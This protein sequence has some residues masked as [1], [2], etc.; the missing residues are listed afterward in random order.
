MTDQRIG[1]IC[2]VDCDCYILWR[3]G[4]SFQL[5]WL[6]Q[7]MSSI[8]K[9]ILL[10]KQDMVYGLVTF[11]YYT[12]SFTVCLNSY[13]ANCL[14]LNISI[15]SINLFKVYGKDSKETNCFSN[16]TIKVFVT[17]VTDPLKPQIIRLLCLHYFKSQL[18]I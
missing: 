3:N 12:L 6:G 5:V 15:S 11:R 4:F 13:T 17:Y 14:A 7:I 16:M 9:V 8:C 10:S 2:N 18:L 1:L